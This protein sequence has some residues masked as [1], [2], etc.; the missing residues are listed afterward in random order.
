MVKAASEA[1]LDDLLAEPITQ[2]V[3]LR[4]GVTEAEVRCLIARVAR[5]LKRQCTA[6]PCGAHNHGAGR[7]EGRGMGAG[8]ELQGPPKAVS[9]TDRSA[10]YPTS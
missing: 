5:R 3:M 1:T 9:S 7:V 2:L 8:A 10:P 4:D 6:L